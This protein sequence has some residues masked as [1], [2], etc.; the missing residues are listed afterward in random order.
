LSPICSVFLGSAD[1][2]GNCTGVSA[3]LENAEQKKEELTKSQ[4]ENIVTVLP[5]LYSLKNL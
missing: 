2:S 1:Y 4:Y 3:A 5:D